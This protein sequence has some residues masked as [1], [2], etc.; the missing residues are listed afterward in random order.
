MRTERGKRTAA[1]LTM[2]GIATILAGVI[3]LR[4]RIRE[5]WFLLELQKG[6]EEAK[7]AAAAKLADIRSARAVPHL[8]ALLKATDEED[9]VDHRQS[10]PVLKVHYAAKALVRI[11]SPAW[12]VLRG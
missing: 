5:E 12:P 11:G 7:K 1:I 4:G 2:A 9:L 6:D 10:P 8:M 3:A